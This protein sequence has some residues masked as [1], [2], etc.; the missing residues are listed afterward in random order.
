MD[1]SQA[2]LDKPKNKISVPKSLPKKL[3][4]YTIGTDIPK[5][6][7]PKLKLKLHLNQFISEYYP[8][9][10]DVIIRVIKLKYLHLNSSILVEY[11]ANKITNKKNI[12]RQYRNILERIELPLY[13]KHSYSSHNMGLVSQKD[14]KNRWLNELSINNISN[15]T[16]NRLKE[17][18]ERKKTKK[19]IINKILSLIKYKGLIGV[20]FE[21]AGR[22]TRRNVASMSV[23]KVGQRGTLKNIDSSYKGIPVVNLRGNRRPNIDYSSFNSKTTIG[24]FNVKGWGSYYYSTL[25]TSDRASLQDRP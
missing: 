5:L 8:S 7:Y 17:L 9:N 20:R 11:L 1:N 25:A 2:F 14:G 19:F 13:L 21:I 10:K 12:L 3:R 4:S 22:L 15:I 16:I 18:G 24:T 6:K 23:F